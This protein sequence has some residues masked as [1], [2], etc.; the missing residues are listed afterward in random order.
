MLGW[1]LP[2]DSQGKPWGRLAW[3][4][5]PAAQT[6]GRGQNTPGKGCPAVTPHGKKAPAPHACSRAGQGRDTRPLVIAAPT[7]L[8]ELPVPLA[9]PGSLCCPRALPHQRGVPGADGQHSLSPPVPRDRS[10]AAGARRSLQACLRVQARSCLVP[11]GSRA[12]APALGLGAGS[13]CFPGCGLS[14]LRSGDIH[15]P[16]QS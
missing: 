13:K 5:E 6:C 15:S 8:A 4:L 2:P 1:S 9:A 12:S 7:L 3:G 11:D 10:A 14:P 16:L